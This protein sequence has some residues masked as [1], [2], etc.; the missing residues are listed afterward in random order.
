[1]CKKKQLLEHHMAYKVLDSRCFDFK[2][3]SAMLEGKIDENE[4]CSLLDYRLPTNYEYFNG[5][6]SKSLCKKKQLL[7]HHMA[8]K[9]LD[10]VLLAL[11]V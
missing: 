3:M 8:F 11:S 6:F 10:L 2:H 5:S 1:M 9:V 4:Y 7:K